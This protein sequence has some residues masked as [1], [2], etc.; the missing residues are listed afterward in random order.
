VE[1]AEILEARQLLDLAVKAELGEEHGIR[2]RLLHERE[3]RADRAGPDDAHELVDEPELGQHAPEAHARVVLHQLERL[4]IAA[5]LAAAFVDQHRPRMAEN[6]GGIAL[7]LGHRVGEHR[8]RPE[9]IRAR[10]LHVRR[11]TSPS[12]RLKLPYRPMFTALRW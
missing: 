10:E 11:P 4:L 7:H 9:I 2:R 3:H 8:R 1:A 6:Q 12:S 5:D